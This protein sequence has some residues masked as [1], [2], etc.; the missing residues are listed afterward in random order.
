MN[1]PLDV[2][3]L[4]ATPPEAAPK[5][6]QKRPEAAVRR[7]ARKVWE[8]R[9]IFVVAQPVGFDQARGISYGLRGMPDDLLLFNGRAALV[10][11]KAGTGRLADHQRAFHEKH[12]RHAP[13]FIIDTK[14]GAERVGALLTGPTWPVPGADLRGLP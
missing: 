1:S 9:G 5:K 6:K 2:N 7:A 4:F 10:E 12:A 13:T 11:A 3:A 14:G 8:A